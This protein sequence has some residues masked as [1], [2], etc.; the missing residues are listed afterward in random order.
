M[1]KQTEPERFSGG[2]TCVMIDD[3]EREKLPLGRFEI[4]AEKFIYGTKEQREII[5]S[6]LNEKEKK[7]FLKG[8]GLY[9]LFTDVNYYKT[10]CNAIGKQI[11]EELH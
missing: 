9:R 7:T 1:Q 10:V 6:F 8:I 3:K 5:L 11:Y 4:I 2:K